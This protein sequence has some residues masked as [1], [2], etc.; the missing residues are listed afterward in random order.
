MDVSL[1][2]TYPYK[3][4]LGYALRRWGQAPTLRIIR[5]EASAISSPAKAFSEER[6]LQL[7]Q[8][9]EPG[10]TLQDEVVRPAP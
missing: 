3:G 2:T 6:L 10:P 5:Q 7:G 4:P 8:R 1:A 9:G